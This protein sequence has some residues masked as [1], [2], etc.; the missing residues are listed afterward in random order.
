MPLRR[1][2]IFIFFFLGQAK[3]AIY[4]SQVKSRRSYLR[5]GERPKEPLVPF[6]KKNFESR[7]LEFE[8]TR[9]PDRS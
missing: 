6:L 9:R 7:L 5:E 1:Y 2:K 3:T 8:A 4:M